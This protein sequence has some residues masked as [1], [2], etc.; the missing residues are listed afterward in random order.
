[1]TQ[2]ERR[3]FARG[4]MTAFLELSTSPHVAAHVCAKHGVTAEEVASLGNVHAPV[5][6]MV[7]LGSSA[8]EEVRE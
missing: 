6:E 7:D 1:M 3:A 2:G 5:L 4:L 8:S